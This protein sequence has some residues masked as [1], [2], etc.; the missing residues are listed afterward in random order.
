VLVNHPCFEITGKGWD[1]TELGRKE[2]LGA[3]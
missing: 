2:G 1:L 3:D